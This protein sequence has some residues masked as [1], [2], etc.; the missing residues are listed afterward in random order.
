MNLVIDL[1]VLIYINISK[2]ERG[3]I[4]LYFT[5]KYL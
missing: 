5:A 3:C 1:I 4:T 2:N